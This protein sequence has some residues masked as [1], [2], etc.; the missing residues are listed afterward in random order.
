MTKLR[1]SAQQFSATSSPSQGFSSASTSAPSNFQAREL[2]PYTGQPASAP[3]HLNQS[4]TK[5][6]TVHTYYT[7]KSCGPYAVHPK[8]L[9]KSN[10]ETDPA[11]LFSTPAPALS[12]APISP[13][14]KLDAAQFGLIEVIEQ[15]TNSSSGEN[16]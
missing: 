5:K 8:V 10:Y 14:F 4:P 15:Q 6:S 3:Q 16:D 13:L 9:S 2:T 7:Q 12:S 11:I 1:Q